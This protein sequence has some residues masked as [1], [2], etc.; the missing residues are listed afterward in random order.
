VDRLTFREVRPIEG[1]LPSLEDDVLT[2]TE[3]RA[4][5]ARLPTLEDPWC[6]QDPPCHVLFGSYPD[7]MM[8]D[9]DR[10][11]DH[12]CE[13]IGR[14]TTELWAMLHPLEGPSLEAWSSRWPLPVGRF[15]LTC[16]YERWRDPHVGLVAPHLPF[17]GDQRALI[18]T[19][20]TVQGQLVDIFGLARDVRCAEDGKPTA[21]RP[22]PFE[23]RFLGGGFPTKETTALLRRARRWWTTRI[24]ARPMRSGRNAGRPK[25]RGVRYPTRESYVG[26]IRALPE[27]TSKQGWR[28]RELPDW[29]IARLLEIGTS[30]M[31]VRN[32]AYGITL[33]DIHEGKV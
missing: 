18:A 11:P 13:K 8:G 25:R 5:E 14:R 9:E 1:E 31:Y 15:A 7:V 26:A 2:P 29:R 28:L 24:E 30:T 23:H 21:W 3:V 12:I 10:W 16:D 19:R 33:D 32:R 6:P 20:C 4:I 27:R 22:G 17:D